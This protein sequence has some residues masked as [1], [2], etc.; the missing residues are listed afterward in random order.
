MLERRTPKAYW[1]A[2]LLCVLFALLPTAANAQ[3]LSTTEY[4][5][6]LSRAIEALQDIEEIEEA[7]SP[8][9]YQN[10]LNRALATVREALPE[11]QSVQ[12]SDEVC[13]VDNTWLHEALKEIEAATRRKESGSHRAH[14]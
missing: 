9:Y 11:H 6:N 14:R 7:E 12:S 1:F 2:V 13:N 5:Q 4:E 10:E 3:H 8:Y